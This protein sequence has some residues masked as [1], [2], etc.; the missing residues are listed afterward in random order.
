MLKNKK[1]KGFTLLETVATIAIVSIVTLFFWIKVETVQEKRDLEISSRIISEVYLKYIRRSIE[2]NEEYILDIYLVDK[3]IEIKNKY[4]KK[5]ETVTLPK[6]L[7]YEV[8]YDK[9][10][11]KKFTTSTTSNGNL[12]KSFSI[13]IFNYKKYLKRKITFYVFNTNKILV[14]NNYIKTESEK[15][16]QENIIKYHYSEENQNNKGWLYE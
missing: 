13:Y 1:A 4:E 11:Y 15:I 2:L 12:S 7:F 8:V 10:L 3:K 6:K 5:I 9:K 14:I 16:P